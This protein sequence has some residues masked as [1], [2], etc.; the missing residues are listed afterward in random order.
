VNDMAANTDTRSAATPDLMTSKPDADSAI[1]CAWCG[2]AAPDGGQ[3]LTWSSSV[4]GRGAAAVT[5]LYCDRCSRE[6]VRGIESK[7]DAAWW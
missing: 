1:T 6:H 3:P 4:E 7:L 5:R 2:V